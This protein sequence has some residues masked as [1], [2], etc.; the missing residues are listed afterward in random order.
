MFR[1]SPDGGSCFAGPSRADHET[2][3]KV[4]R[5]L[6]DHNDTRP[7]I[8]STAMALE[9]AR[10]ALRR[11][12]WRELRHCERCLPTQTRGISST[13]PTKSPADDIERS[14]VTEPGPSEEIVSTFDPVKQAKERGWQLPSGR[15][16]KAFLIAFSSPHPTPLR[17][18]HNFHLV[19]NNLADTS[20]DRQNTTE[21]HFTRTNLRRPQIP[22][23]ANSFPVPSPPLVSNKPMKP[24]SPLTCSP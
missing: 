23:L 22:P 11:P 15:Y 4:L 9:G 12:L 16:G 8:G 20:F 2:S 19:S 24:P 5:L 17:P 14:S 21:A 13:L 6:R 1:R 7:R 18:L 10:L 3:P